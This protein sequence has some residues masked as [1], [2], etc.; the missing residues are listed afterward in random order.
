MRCR[1]TLPSD[2]SRDYVCPH[3]LIPSCHRCA[4]VLIKLIYQ[5]AG[6][7]SELSSASACRP[8]SPRTGKD[9]T[10]AA[11]DE[12]GPVCATG[13]PFRMHSSSQS[14]SACGSHLQ[15]RVDHLPICIFARK[16]SCAR[17][18]LFCRTEDEVSRPNVCSRPEIVH[19]EDCGIGRGSFCISPT[20]ILPD[21]LATMLLVLYMFLPPT[22]DCHDLQQTRIGSTKPANALKCQRRLGMQEIS[23]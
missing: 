14:L 9:E 21:D 3:L 18:C 5:T 6:T 15:E 20:D 1:S 16:I 8:L 13:W 11:E 10:D 22:R 17:G 4:E 19:S 7:C 23:V 2:V 12:A